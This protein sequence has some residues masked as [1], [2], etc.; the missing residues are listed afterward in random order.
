MIAIADHGSIS[1]AAQAL[2]ITQSG[3]NQQ[4]IKLEKELNAQIF[5][6]DKHN[7]QMTQAGK[8][9]IQNAREIMNIKKCAYTQIYDLVNSNCGEIVLGLTAEHGIDMFAEIF[10]EF[11]KVFPGITLKL[12]ECFVK[13]QH[14][15]LKKG[16]LDLGFVMLRE[17]DKVDLE[18]IHLCRERLVLGGFTKPSPGKTIRGT[19]RRTLSYD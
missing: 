9:Y 19:S 18:Y 10:P 6:R 13:T 4:L 15:L 2:F 16:Q 11:T 14:K 1:K 7:L 3:L 8:I 5:Y 12:Q 17:E